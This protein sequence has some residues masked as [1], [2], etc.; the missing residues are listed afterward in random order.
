MAVGRFGGEE[1]PRQEFSSYVAHPVTPLE[2]AVGPS[3]LRHPEPE[4]KNRKMCGRDTEA[5]P[6][7]RRDSESR[8]RYAT[9]LLR[10][11]HVKKCTQK[12]QEEPVVDPR[13]GSVLSFSPSCFVPA[14]PTRLDLSTQG[15]LSIQLPD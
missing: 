5:R 1:T 10:I 3:T 13:L 2:V 11:V 6:K 8:S 12:T 15:G 7:G 4:T 14:T 9:S